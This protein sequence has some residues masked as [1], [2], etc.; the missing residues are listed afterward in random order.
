MSFYYLQGDKSYIIKK[1]DD[2]IVR[3]NLVKYVKIKKLIVECTENMFVW[4][5]IFLSLFFK[6]LE[7]VFFLN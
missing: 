3:K 5:W 7:K 1:Y 4:T 6:E 2:K